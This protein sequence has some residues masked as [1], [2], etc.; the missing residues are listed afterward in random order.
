MTYTIKIEVDE[1]I[2]RRLYPKS[3]KTIQEMV[4][5]ELGWLQH[6]GISVVSIQKSDF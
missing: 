4:E 5:T 1:K 2:I 6:S 3:G